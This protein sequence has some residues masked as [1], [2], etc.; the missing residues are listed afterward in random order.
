[1]AEEECNPIFRFESVHQLVERIDRQPHVFGHRGRL[2]F[3]QV[4]RSEEQEPALPAPSAE[5]FARDEDRDLRDE[6]GQ[7]LG[8][9]ERLEPI[10]HTDED[11]L[12]AVV[13]IERA[14]DSEDDA[15]DEARIPLDELAFGPRFTCHQRP[16]ELL[17]RGS[18]VGWRGAADHC[19]GRL[20]TTRWKVAATPPNGSRTR[21]GTQASVDPRSIRGETCRLS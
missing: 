8:V 9:A 18:A 21:S 20:T 3:G 11:L 12:D 19:K 4:G 10:E 2:D 7:A 15:L 14:G 5:R 17:R 6:P 16:C 13:E 1:V